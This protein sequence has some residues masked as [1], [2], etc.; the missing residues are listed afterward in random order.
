MQQ[1]PGWQEKPLS[2]I[3]TV[4]CKIPHAW[5][6]F[7][8]VV[9]LSTQCLNPTVL[10]QQQPL[11]NKHN[12]LPSQLTGSWGSKPVQLETPAYKSLFL[13][14]SPLARSIFIYLGCMLRN[15]LILHIWTTTTSP[16]QVA[17]NRFHAQVLHEVT[18]SNM[19]GCW[20][21]ELH[22]LTA[23]PSC[24]THTVHYR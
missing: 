18:L 11:V 14:V 16:L 21:D 12:L 22:A 7:Q 23:W 8:L 15:A 3:A 13:S 5:R 4:R 10:R 6:L 19:P 2:R 20:G 17:Q 9:Y 24:Q 1:P